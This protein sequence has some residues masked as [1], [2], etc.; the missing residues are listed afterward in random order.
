MDLILTK[1]MRNDPQDLDDIRFIM[2]QQ[3]IAPSALIVAFKNVLPI[4]VPEITQIF[5]RMQP[6]VLKMALEIGSVDRGKK[7]PDG[8]T[9]SLDPDWWSKL[10]EP[11]DAEQRLNND[12]E[13]EL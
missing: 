13:I 11:P 7:A 9:R 4:E 6:V 3:D 8:L 1:M 12:R 2:M 5:V 10:N